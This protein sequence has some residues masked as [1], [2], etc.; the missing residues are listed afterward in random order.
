ML[1]D[2]RKVT[3]YEE[4]SDAY[5]VRRNVFIKEQGVSETDEHDTFEEQATH[6]VGY[7]NGE[8]FAA[9]RLRFIEDYAKLERICVA[10]PHRGHSFGKQIIHY[11]ET[12]IKDEGYSKAKL[13]S[14]THAEGFYESL[15]Y[16]TV[17]EEFMDAGIPHVTMIKN[18]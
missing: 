12:V 11:M 8:P 7:F 14:Q 17:S 3:N 10:K 5:H 4:L 2:I 1:A 9:A 16:H 13:N 15:G 18:L 6:I